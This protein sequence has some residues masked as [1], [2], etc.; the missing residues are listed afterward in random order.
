MMRSRF[1]SP[2]ASSA[3]VSRRSRSRNSL[4]CMALL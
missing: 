2:A 1:N 4:P 3:S